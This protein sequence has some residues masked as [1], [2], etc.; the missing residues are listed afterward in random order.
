MCLLWSRVFLLTEAS[1]LRSDSPWASPRNETSNDCGELPNPVAA[2]N[3]M[4]DVMKPFMTQSSKICVIFN[5]FV[6]A[7]RWYIDIMSF[8]EYRVTAL[9]FGCSPSGSTAG[10]HHCIWQL[11]NFS[12]PRLTGRQW[13]LEDAKTDSWKQSTYNEYYRGSYSTPVLTQSTNR[14]TRLVRI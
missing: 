5:S 3:M 1:Y 2:M 13:S 8:R 6:R 11:G 10:M 7:L 14:I 12:N 4:Q 9:V